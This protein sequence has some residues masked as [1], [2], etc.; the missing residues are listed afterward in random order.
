MTRFGLFISLAALLVCASF[1]ETR[2]QR[3][4]EKTELRGWLSDDG[5]GGGRARSGLYTGTNPI[6][7]KKCIREGKKM[8]LVDPEKKRLLTI[9]NP[10]AAMENIG[11][12]V[13]ISGDLNEQAETL[14]IDSL[15]LLEK[16]NAMCKKP[17]KKSDPS[18]SSN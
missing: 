11:D 14:R 8:V 18:K 10:E 6:C 2:A 3:N 5:C 12:Y 17:A 16:G 15:K 1:S 13:E 4:T 9:D 7:A